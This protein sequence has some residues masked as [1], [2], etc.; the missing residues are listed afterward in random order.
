MHY[1]V[2]NRNNKIKLLKPTISIFVF[3][4]MFIATGA[5]NTIHIDYFEFSNIQIKPSS[6]C[7][8]FTAVQNL[9]LVYLV[10]E[11]RKKGFILSVVLLILNLLSTIIPLIHG[12]YSSIAGIAS[13]LVA[14]AMLSALNKCLDRI[15]NSEE[16]LYK[17]AGT[18]A[19]TGLPNRRSL[20]EYLKNKVQENISFGLVFIDLDNF[21]NVNDTMGHEYG[22][23]VLCELTQRWNNILGKDDFIAR[24][25]GDE[26]ALVVNDYKDKD[27]LLDRVGIYLNVLLDTF[28]L[29]DED[30]FISASMG[31]SCYP[32]QSTDYEILLRYAD[33]AMY[34]AKREGKK[35]ISLFE[36]K[37]MESIKEDVEM[38]SKIR[39]A[40]KNK[41]F[42]L[43]FQPQFE[44]GTHKLRGFETLV[45]MRDEEGDIISPGL[46]IPKAEKTNMIIDID[47]WVLDNA[48]KY[49][50]QFL[51]FNDKLI[52]SVNISVKHL[53]NEN[54][55]DDVKKALN[56]ND[57]PAENLEIEITE[58]LFITS[59]SR[60]AKL[61]NELK[62][63]GVHIALD[64]FGTGYASLSYLNKLPIDILKVDKSFI[65]ELH[66]N[67]EN[68][69]FVKA[70]VSMGHTLKFQVVSEGV[71]KE[72]QLKILHGF[73]CDYVQGYIWGKPMDY[74]SAEE[75][76]NEEI[77]LKV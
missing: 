65:D 39:R 10:M 37:Q 28:H 55:I 14:F 4:I 38:E 33:T 20:T 32:E 46:F 53:Q 7:G 59:L 67:G 24:L 26:F 71:E 57:F 12:N 41:S 19:L 58:S 61:L 29:D 63:L 77:S 70:I 64:D 16:D 3:L 36:T 54:L 25:G 18:D 73:N 45:R 8:V 22:D 35:Q 56:D 76:V 42:Y 74:N 27:E 51:Q 43:N 2:I 30:F 6:L 48:L 13:I 72:E 68:N 40:I 1:T 49:F 15:Q 69:D 75:L 17:M 23:K 47:K 44:I 21:K 66:E 9:A 52:V 60:S 5:V 34:D 31:I 62:E 50:K 11:L